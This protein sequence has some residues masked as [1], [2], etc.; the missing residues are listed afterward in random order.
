[1][2]FPK[3]NNLKAIII[4]EHPKY[5]PDSKQYLDYWREQKKRCIEG[6]WYEDLPSQWRYC[7]P[8][9]YFYGNMGTII[10]TDHKSKLRRLTRPSMR[11]VEWIMLTDYMV[12]KGFSGFE[13]DEEFT[14][15]I[16]VVTGDLLTP[17]C[18][19][20][21]GTLKTY[22]SPL[23][24]LKQLHD[25]PKGKP[26]Y[27]NDASNVF[28]LGSRGLGKS[29][30]VAHIILHELL[31]DGQKE[32]TLAQ[33]EARTEIFVG[34]F[35]ADKS[36]ELLSKVETALNSLPGAFGGGETYRPAPFYKEMSGTLK[37]GNTKSPYKHEYKKKENGT[38]VTAGSGSKILHEVFTVENPQAAAGSRPSLIV[39]EEVGLLPNVKDVHG[40]NTAAQI[41]GGRKMG[42]SIYL[43][44]GGNMDKIAESEY[45][46]RRPKEYNIVAHEDE[47]ENTGEIGLFIPV[48]YTY[49]D[50]KDKNGNTKFDLADKRVETE[51]KSK[52]WDAL[53]HQKMNYP[54]SPSEMFLSSRGTMFPQEEIQQQLKYIIK[55]QTIIDRFTS[56][57]KLVY[58]IDAANGVSFRPDT[59]GECVP[60][61]D[62]PTKKNTSIRGCLTIYEHPPEIIP[63]GLYKITYDIVKD[64]NIYEMS[65]G[66][67]LAAVYVYKSVQRFD[68]VYDQ[69]VGH[70][71]GRYPNVDDIHELAIKMALYFNAKIMVETN[72]PGFYKY[73]LHNK[74]L[75]ILARTPFM[76][77]GKIEPGGKQRLNIGI[78]M[79]TALIIQAEQYLV[80]WL[81][82]EREASYDELG[83]KLSSKR[84]VNFIYDKALLEELLS[85]NRY[86]N[87]D[88]VTAL[89]LL[90]LWLEE[91][92]EHP[93][94]KPID[95]QELEH[96]MMSYLRSGK[97]FNKTQAIYG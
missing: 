36:S 15:N 88:R 46:F 56:H 34:A 38:W 14:S 18:Y 25:K 87:T 42:T 83:N 68:G 1:M 64:D 63:E 28:I 4:N 60:I 30:T 16:A 94:V 91:A 48:Q 2:L 92:K 54:V 45:I 50:L 71:V 29:Y 43:G 82:E 70:Y 90:M 20:Q 9:F 74:R 47:W 10:D 44:T 23:D 84:N 72:L 11:D 80:R 55:N 7:T 21:D 35:K 51:R 93:E 89:L 39:I 22:I 61:T 6:Y 78:Y 65:K 69:I 31:F 3:I 96:P 19:K 8:V 13:D 40:S 12:A 81:L 66:V 32:Y 33:R 75:N 62:Y 24:Y 85:Y 52:R 79:S 17:A 76:T 95:E 41:T 67:S 59:S 5:H 26:L 53:Q 77:I 57:G 37:V 27:E 49:S 97:M 86:V 58:D 73:C